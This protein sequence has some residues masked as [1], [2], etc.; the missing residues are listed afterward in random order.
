MQSMT[1]WYLNEGSMSRCKDDQNAV[2]H[3]AYKQSLPLQR[4]RNTLATFL[5]PC[6][7]AFVSL[8]SGFISRSKMTSSSFA[9]A[10]RFPASFHQTIPGRR[11]SA[12]RTMS[13]CSMLLNCI[14]QSSFGTLAE[15]AQFYRVLPS[16]QSE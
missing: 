1:R 11:Q 4:L 7:S 10:P 9:T 5:T 14:H 12:W 6:F 15:I 8:I 13:R 3:V 2:F 16:S